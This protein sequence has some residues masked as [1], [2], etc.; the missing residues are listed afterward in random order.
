MH[1]F[2]VNRSDSLTGKNDTISFDDGSSAKY[3]VR[4]KTVYPYEG[5][6]WL[7]WSDSISW[8]VSY[9]LLL[10]RCLSSS[11]TETC[12]QDSPQRHSSLDDP[13]VLT[14]QRKDVLLS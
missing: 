11:A 3:M 2:D 8:Q 4:T 13:V 12:G 7:R 14:N 1:Y 5:K 6:R 9:L 10:N